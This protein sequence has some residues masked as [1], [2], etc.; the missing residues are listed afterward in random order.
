MTGKNKNTA[1][2]LIVD[3]EPELRELIVDALSDSGVNVS[4]A[5]NG[6]EAIELARRIHPDIV[7]TDLCLGDCSG[8]DVIDRLGDVPA[9][10]ITGRG[11]AL[12]LTEASR[13]RPVELMTKPLNL[14]RLRNTISE[15]LDRLADSRQNQDDHSLLRKTC[16]SMTREYRELSDQLRLHQ[17][18]LGYQAELIA[19][20][21]DDD[22]FRVF[23]QTFVRQSSAVCGAALV[24]DS[25]AELRI[26]GRFGVPRPDGLEFCQHLSE[27]LIEL[28][29]NNPTVQYV[30]AGD[31]PDIF[32]ESIRRYLPGLSLLIIPLIPAPGEMIG[33]IMLYRKGEQPFTEDDVDLAQIIAH[34]TALAVRRND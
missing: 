12:S 8:L 15:E 24:C 1:R 4:T 6:K 33:M 29:L 30:E 11:D 23:F 22:V 19:A 28:L 2:I 21:T 13:R 27:P 7:I 17:V 18:L 3:D 31:E 16:S 26:T 9:V 34:P 32:D 14:E 20:K 25:N 5:G 10:V